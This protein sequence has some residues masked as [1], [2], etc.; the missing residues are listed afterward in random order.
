VYRETTSWDCGPLSNDTLP[1]AMSLQKEAFH[2]V[3]FFLED[4]LEADLGGMV[5][6]LALMTTSRLADRRPMLHGI[7]AK[8]QRIA[9]MKLDRWWLLQ[10]R[11]DD[12]YNELAAVANNDPNL[13]QRPTQVDWVDAMLICKALRDEMDQVGQFFDCRKDITGR[14]WDITGREWDIDEFHDRVLMPTFAKWMRL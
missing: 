7:G 14:E 9:V 3:A 10:K 13:A 4:G 5:D 11:F 6:V 8:F 12:A 2:L 1:V